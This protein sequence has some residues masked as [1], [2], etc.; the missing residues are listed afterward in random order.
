[1]VRQ[2]E[3]AQPSAGSRPPRACRRTL[4]TPCCTPS[5]L[6]T[7]ESG[8]AAIAIIAAAHGATHLM[9]DGWR[10][11]SSAAPA[12]YGQDAALAMLPAAPIPVLPGTTGPVTRG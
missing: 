9:A 3:E 5:G 2:P 7:T 10:E 8:T 4:S 6:G 1:M 11:P 12:V